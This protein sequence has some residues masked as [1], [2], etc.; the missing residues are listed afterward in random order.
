M[1]SKCNKGYVCARLTTILV[2]I[3]PFNNDTLS[4]CCSSLTEELLLEPSVPGGMPD[5]RMSLGLSFFYKFYLA[6]AN[7]IAAGTIPTNELP[8]IEVYTN[9]SCDSYIV[10]ISI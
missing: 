8:A 9:T 7:E 6:V 4:I 5:Y 2:I 10:N 3:R 1:E